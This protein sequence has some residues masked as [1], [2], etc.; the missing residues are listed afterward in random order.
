[1]PVRVKVWPAIGEQQGL[2]LPRGQAAAD[3]CSP[4]LS[5][6]PGHALASAGRH[7]HQVVLDEPVFIKHGAGVVLAGVKGCLDGWEQQQAPCALLCE[8]RLDHGG[9]LGLARLYSFDGDGS[10]RVAS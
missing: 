3:A 9:Q 6:C 10:H 2:L 1:M 7:Q 4:G 8:Q 5:V